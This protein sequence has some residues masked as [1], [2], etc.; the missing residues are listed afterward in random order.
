M[1]PTDR[2]RPTT[3]EQPLSVSSAP[4][5]SARSA[6]R[7]RVRGLLLALWVATLA[8]AIY[9]VAF[10]R[11]FVQGGLASAT[12]ASALAGAAIFLFFGSVRGF[13]LVPSTALIVVAIPFFPPG[14]LFALTMAGILISAASIYWFAEALHL[15]ELLARRQQ[16]Q[17][18]RL[19]RLLERYEL[20]VIIGWSVFPFVPTD[21][22]CYVCGVLRVNF[23][24]YLLGVGIGEGVICAA[25]I[26]VGDQAARWLELKP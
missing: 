10:N 4:R 14:R 18:A 25:Y 26:F 24:K 22:M 12:S 16:Q 11:E 5:A 9:V 13:T 17:V 1:T 19:S 2:R 8:S 15:E 23:A 7:Q 3:P 6:W 21:L 20:P